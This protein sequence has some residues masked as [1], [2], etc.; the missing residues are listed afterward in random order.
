[1]LWYLLY[2]DSEEERGKRVTKEGDN[3]E[4][5]ARMAVLHVAVACR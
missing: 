2:Y 3:K 1:M 5:T 4:R